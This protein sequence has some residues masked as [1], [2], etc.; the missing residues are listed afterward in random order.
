MDYEEQSVQFVNKNNLS[1]IS[2]SQSA[3]LERRI[4]EIAEL[5]SIMADE[6][7]SLFN[8]GYG[9]YEIVEM[10]RETAYTPNYVLHKEILPQNRKCIGA[11]LETI[12]SN[13]KGVFAEMLA[14]ALE[15][16]KYKISELDFLPLDKGEETVT[17]VKNKLSDEAYDVFSQDMHDPRVLY[18]SS[19]KDAAVAV[20]EGKIRYCILPLEELG[21]ARLFGIEQIIFKYDLK[22]NS[23]TPVFGVDG[24]TD[25]K[26]ALVSKQFFVPDF[27]LDDDRYLEIK[28]Q[29]DDGAELL[30]I[31][32]AAKALGIDVYRINTL[33]IDFGDEES[34]GFTLVL[35]RTGKEFVD[36]LTY[37]AFFS[38][39]HTVVGIYKNL[40]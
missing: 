39:S 16:K 23:I 15:E 13:D 6:I 31:I 40:E 3:D 14:N 24:T 29:S 18:S 4:C 30:Q 26:Y 1:M 10:L 32:T 7:I 21:G 34:A 35:K 37:L 38:D 28:I 19:F 8:D 25:M 36:M 11:Y 20:A 22:I 2:L 5:A 12:S 33:R 9:I 27:S 17:Y